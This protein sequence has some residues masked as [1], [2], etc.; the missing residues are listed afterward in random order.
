[1]AHNS[2]PVN[3]RHR[4]RKPSGIRDVPRYLRELFITFFV[5]LFYILT[6]VWEAKPSLLFWML[7]ISVFNGVAPVIGSVIAARIL[8]S[9]AQVYAGIPM[10]FAAISVLLIWQ[11][12]YTLIRTGVTQLYSL[13]SS[14]SGELVANHVKVKI[15]E[16]SKTID[17]VSYDSPDY[18]ARLENANREAGNRPIQV[19]TSTFTVLS[20]II[21]MVSYIVVLFTVSYTAPLFIIL[22]SIP[23]AVVTF[24]YRNKN[25]AYMFG[26]SRN[27]REMDY[28]ASTMVNKDLVKE[29]RMFSLADT[30]IEKYSAAFDTYFK[31]LK[32]LKF[33]E[34]LWKLGCSLLSGVVHCLLF[35]WLA[36]QVYNGR[37]EVG[38]FS[39]YTGAI[40]AIGSGVGTL[41]ATV[42]SIYEGTLFIENLRAFL[43]EDHGIVP[44]V[45]EPRHVTRGTGHRIELKNVSFRYPGMDHDVLK[46]LTATIHP[47]ETVS[48]VGLNGAGKTTLIKLITRLYDPTEGVIL[49]DGHDIRE[50]DVNELYA[51]YGIIFQD[52]GKYAVTA[53]E[54]IAF[55]DLQKELSEEDIQTAA[56]NSGADTII[57]NLRDRYDTPLMRYFD[58]DGAELSIGQWQKLAIARAFYADADI[59]IL[60]E[61]TASLD[62]M[63]E[64]DIFN[65]FNELRK[66]KTGIFISHRL[67]SATL[68]D[69]VFVMENGQIVEGGSHREL[70]ELGGRYYTLFSTQ[71]AHYVGT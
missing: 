26:R 46:N 62:P 70:M 29:I 53:G 66:G 30:L 37:M 32:K 20:T 55:G 13:I 22:V 65:R 54:N 16:K 52:F 8:N 45:D 34:F 47:G 38:S 12:T 18:Y 67:S 4:V 36:K 69:T 48:I 50:Y 63:A 49:L 19:M 25:V 59:L 41:I 56:K 71:A 33:S 42:G 28:Y 23:T 15:M 1:M 11:F 43:N 40:E 51:A 6:L 7:F 31:G 64:Q 39:L 5:R 27:R 3:D 60:D 68:A 2:A 10:V 24:I 61:P 44:S 17:M 14:V 58:K 35:I 21:S 57:Q 9:L